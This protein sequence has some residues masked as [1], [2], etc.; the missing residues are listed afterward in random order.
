MDIFAT[1]ENPWLILVMVIW[2]FP[3]KAWALWKSA[4]NGQKCW[5]LALLLLNTLA[6]LEIV[7][8]FIFSKRKK[9]EVKSEKPCS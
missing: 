1:L 5:F 3:W 9:P 8:I 7:Y 2:I 6:V 4:R